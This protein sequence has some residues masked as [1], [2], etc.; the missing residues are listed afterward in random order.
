MFSYLFWRYA[1][2]RAVKTF[3]QTLLALFSA[4]GI[5]L[6][7]IPWDSSLSAASM[8]AILSV[9]TSMTSEPIGERSTPSVLPAAPVAGRTAEVVEPAEPVTSAKV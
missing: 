9:L 3:A 7:N 4:G 5:G 8:A 6:F 1:F 2:E